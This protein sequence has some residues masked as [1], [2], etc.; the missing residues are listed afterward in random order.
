MLALS[1]ILQTL[2][3]INHKKKSKSKLF[4]KQQLN[5]GSTLFGTTYQKASNAD[6]L[7]THSLLPDKWQNY[8]YIFFECG[9][10][11]VFLFVYFPTA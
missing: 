3:V 5:E 2:E 4:P 1:G 7:K 9:W 6:L 11:V 8:I 10:V